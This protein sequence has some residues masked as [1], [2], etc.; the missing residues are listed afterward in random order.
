MYDYISIDQNAPIEDYRADRI[1]I[2]KELFHW[3]YLTQEEQARFN[4]STSKE[5]ITRLLVTAR[6]RAYTEQVSR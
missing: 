3:D 2:C 4:T 1:R 5:E 6:T